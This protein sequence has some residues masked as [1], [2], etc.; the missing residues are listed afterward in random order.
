MP[1]WRASRCWQRRWGAVHCSLWGY[2][3]PRY[4]ADFL[5]FLVLGAALGFVD[6]WR[7]VGGRSRRV[8]VVALVSMGVLGVYGVV[9][10]VGIAVTPNGEWD[11]TQALHYVHA[12]K[13]AADVTGGQLAATTSCA[14]RY[15]RTGHR[16]RSCSSPT[17]ARRSTSPP[18]KP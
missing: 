10:N 15:C 5:P 8:R 1:V 4:L 7:R 17:S 18:A 3:A 13:T 11:T 12:Q 2:I 14:V 9:A 16:P 6:L